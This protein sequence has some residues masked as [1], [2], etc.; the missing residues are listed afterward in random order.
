MRILAWTFFFLNLLCGVPLCQAD[1][2]SNAAA[3]NIFGTVLS[4]FCPGRLLQDCPS[5]KATE[6]KDAIRLRLEQ[7]ESSEAVIDS[8]YNTYGD[9][10][11]ALPRDNFMGLL[12]WLMPVAFLL[13]GFL[14]FY[15]WTLKKTGVTEGAAQGQPLS[16]QELQRLQKELNR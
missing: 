10:I 13:I 7:G 11:R 3:D 8:L 5:G 9:E 6:L 4:P 12:A 1:E 14:I 16:E 2:A 15:R